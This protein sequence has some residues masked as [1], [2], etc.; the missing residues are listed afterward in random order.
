MSLETA[1]KL[2]NRGEIGHMHILYCKVAQQT[3]LDISE[4]GR[5]LFFLQDDSLLGRAGLLQK[6]FPQEPQLPR[7]KEGEAGAAVVTQRL[8]PGE[9]T[10]QW[11]ATPGGGETKAEGPVGLSPRS[12]KVEAQDRGRPRS[13]F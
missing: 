4:A 9:A 3:K 10:G 11:E 12:S 6:A 7:G 8:Q 13:S 2:C 1:G 5:F